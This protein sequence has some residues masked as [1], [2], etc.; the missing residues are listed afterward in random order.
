MRWH[1]PHNQRRLRIKESDRLAVTAEILNQLGGKVKELED[2]LVIEGVGR[3]HG[4]EIDGHSD[5]RI[6]MS[7]AIA[8][9]CCEQPVIIRGAE[10]VSKSYPDFFEVFC[11]LGGAAEEI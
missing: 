8:S 9:T 6:P 7:A 5:H 4:G 10:C 1:F 2:G 3:L 11:S